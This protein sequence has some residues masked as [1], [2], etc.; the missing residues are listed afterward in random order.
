MPS[1]SSLVPATRRGTSAKP[2]ANLNCTSGYRKLVQSQ[3]C[4]N[5]A[6]PPRRSEIATAPLLLLLI[7]LLVLLRFLVLP[8]SSPPT[9][10]QRRSTWR[11]TSPGR[12][13]VLSSL[14]QRARWPGGRQ[15]GTPTGQED[16]GEISLN[17]ELLP[18][19]WIGPALP[20]IHCTAARSLQDHPH[21]WHLSL[22]HCAA[23]LFPDSSSFSIGPWQ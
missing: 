2:V 10:E 5:K 6:R 19:Q 15:A 11:P 3:R 14:V 17:G 18:E 16:A 9:S 20:S 23:S 22:G 4:A 12:I 21:S 7:L 1:P 8:A 13:Q